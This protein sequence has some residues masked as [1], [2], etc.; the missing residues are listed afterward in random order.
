MITEEEAKAVAGN[1]TVLALL[2]TPQYGIRITAKD[3]HIWIRKL[4][5]TGYTGNGQS[6]VG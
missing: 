3:E 2:E 5:S 6:S 1:E 4:Q